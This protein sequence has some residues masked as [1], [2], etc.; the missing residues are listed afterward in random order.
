M[1]K[2]SILPVAMS[3]AALLLAFNA[4]ARPSLQDA[5][6]DSL[7]IIRTNI[8][9]RWDDS[10]LDLGYKGNASSF[11]SFEQAVDSIGLDRI[12]S[13]EIVSQS[14]PEG[15]WE[16]NDALSH[17]RAA[18]MRRYMS[19]R[20][21]QLVDRLTVNPDGESWEQL[22]AFVESDPLISSATR[23]RI[24][25]TID[26]DINLAT[27]K[28]RMQN[29][30]GSD[31]KVGDVYKYLYRTYYP[32][33]RNSAAVTVYSIPRPV[34][35][36]VPEPEPVVVEEPAPEPQQPEVLP[37]EEIVFVPAVA[38]PA[39]EVKAKETIFAL[40]TNLLY[41]AVTMVNF[42]IEVPVG[43]RWSVMWEDVFPWWE[44]S[45]NKFALQNWEMGP[46]VRYWFKPWKHDTNKLLGHFA[47]LYGMSGRGDLQLDLEPNYQVHYWSAGLTYGFCLPLGRRHWGN[48]ELSVSAG[49]LSSDYQH[50]QPTD[51]YD[52][53]MRDPYDSGT[54]SYFGPT[55]AK[56]S[57]VIPFNFFT[58]AA[59]REVSNE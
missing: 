29:R 31:P 28:W 14:S 27:K 4:S 34:I 52:K 58:A 11:D 25:G 36:V 38:V 20:F 2:K 47:G 43:S 50:Y 7:G 40:K 44:F 22:R 19:E 37:E 46:E 17:N 1:L 51:V 33:I 10:R 53:L 48:L 54:V 5:Q 39:P 3:L 12:I 35:V 56:V 42:E 23:E 15:T 8:H 55:K 9:F 26:C 18:T 41:D 49:Y 57:L 13:V 6:P 30:L 45:A 21:P 32:V 16:H 24:L 59:A